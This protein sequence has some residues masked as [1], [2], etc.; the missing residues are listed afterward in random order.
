MLKGYYAHER[1]T[2]LTI[3]NFENVVFN[4]LRSS[5]TLLA[6]Y[7]NAPY[8]IREQ[9]SFETQKLICSLSIVA[10]KAVYTK[11]VKS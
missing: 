8:L 4:S 11:L 7:I 6:R 2:K 3:S 10:S 1:K 9:I 5:D